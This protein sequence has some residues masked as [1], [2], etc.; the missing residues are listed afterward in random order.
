MDYIDL[1]S[2]LDFFKKGCLNMNVQFREIKI[3]G[4]NKIII[5]HDLGKNWHIFMVYQINEILNEIGY[6]IVDE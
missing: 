6:R 4:R 5:Q 1:D 2:I 3:N